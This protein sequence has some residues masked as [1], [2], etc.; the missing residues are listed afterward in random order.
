MNIP[1]ALCPGIRS[2]VLVKQSA[3]GLI[4]RL[5]ISCLMR[6]RYEW[7]AKDLRRTWVLC[8]SLYERG[9]QV[10]MQQFEHSLKLQIERAGELSFLRIQD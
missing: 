9:A 10:S 8:Q 6:R 7:A 2:T 3:I 4:R 5:C 1:A